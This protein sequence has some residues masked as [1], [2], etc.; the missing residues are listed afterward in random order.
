MISILI[1]FSVF[2]AVVLLAVAGYYLTAGRAKVEERRLGQVGAGA[3]TI[4]LSPG[5]VSVL[6]DRR[7]SGFGFL[8]WVL[9]NSSLARGMSLD[10]AR[11][12]VPIRVGEYLLIRWIAAVLLFLV[13]MGLLGSGLFGIVF[14]IIGWF[15]PQLYVKRLQ[16]K[17]LK[18]IEG[19]LMDA[20][21]LISGSIKA[22]FGLLEGLQAIAREMQP[23][24]S[25]E[26]EQVIH[27]IRMGIGIDEALR[28]LSERVKS[29]DMYLMVQ[30]MIIQRQVGGNLSEVLDKIA[31]TIRE[32]IRILGE[33]RIRTA[34]GRLSGLVVGG[35]P[36]ALALIISIINPGHVATFF[37]NPLGQVMLV[38]A[39]IL[40]VIGFLFIRRIVAIEV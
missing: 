39:I 13:G 8:N 28:H 22:G 4:G 7:L 6:R 31:F 30:A 21:S 10:L 33:V 38:A 25:E 18:R 15:L 40:E 12:N 23:P 5:A 1:P 19:Q 34:Q 3:T 36:V 26:F 24:I 29:Y 35:L 14:A 9:V 16:G 17:R 11:A 37:N 27:E 2:L 20:I 32:R